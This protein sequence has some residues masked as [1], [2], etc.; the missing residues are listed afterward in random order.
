MS[1]CH[2][3]NEGRPLMHGG[4]QHMPLYGD[5]GE[6]GAAMCYASSIYNPIPRCPACNKEATYQT[7]DGTYWCASAHYWRANQNSVANQG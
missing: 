4:K 3:C 1:E 6:H 2:F 5:D 7:P